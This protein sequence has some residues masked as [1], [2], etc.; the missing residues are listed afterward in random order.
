MNKGFW[1]RRST[2][3]RMS[4]SI[5]ENKGLLELKYAAEAAYYYAKIFTSTHI[6]GKLE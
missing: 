4:L 5:Y 1:K 2:T 6:Y 3:W